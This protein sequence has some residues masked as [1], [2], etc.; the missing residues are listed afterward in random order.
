MSGGSEHHL[1]SLTKTYLQVATAHKG[2]ASFSQWSLTVYINHP[3][4]KA[5][6]E[7]HRMD[8]GLLLYIFLRGVSY[9]FVWAFLKILLI[10]CLYIMVSGVVW[11][12]CCAFYLAF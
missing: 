8:S 4:G 7:Q 1:P 12:V 9:C 6:D 11:Y 5:A 10:F 3:Q 2:K